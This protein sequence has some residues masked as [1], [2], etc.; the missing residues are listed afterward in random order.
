MSNRKPTS[1]DSPIADISEQWMKTCFMPWTALNNWNAFWGDQ[2]KGWLKGLATAPNPW[3]APLAGGRSDRRV[4]VDFFLPWLPRVQSGFES[5]PVSAEKAML[6]AMFRATLPPLDS[7]GSPAMERALE[8]APDPRLVPVANEAVS[9]GLAAPAPAKAVHKR[10]APKAGA[11]LK[12]VREEGAGTQ[13]SEVSLKPKARRQAP[14]AAHPAPVVK[15]A[16]SK[17]PTAPAPKAAPKP[18]SRA[19]P[20]PKPA[21]KP[22]S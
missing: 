16:T 20:K 14:S 11:K 7:T 8:V 2:W 17:T 15:T 1:T 6:S 9:S 5:A 22:V 19:A 21:A 3:L 18:K 12:L 10:T 13:V 4:E